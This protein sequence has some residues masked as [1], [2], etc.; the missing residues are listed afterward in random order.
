MNSPGRYKRHERN[1]AR[2]FGTERNPNDGLKHNDAENDL[3]GIEV[4]VR[5]NLPKL[6]TDSM[7]QAVRACK[8]GK[9]PIVVLVEAR[10][11][12]KAESYVVMRLSDFKDWHGMA[13]R[14]GSA[15]QIKEEEVHENDQ[16]NYQRGITRIA[17]TSFHRCSSR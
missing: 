16:R 7:K 15:N 5:K 9:T 11:G 10:Q 1:V 13:A 17:S 6:V 4:K 2:E 12:V 8:T 3:F 14:E